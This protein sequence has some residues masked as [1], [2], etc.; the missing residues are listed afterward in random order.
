MVGAEAMEGESNGTIRISHGDHADWSA[1]ADPATTRS[2][3][4]DRGG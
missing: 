4:G 3:G 2:A 1:P